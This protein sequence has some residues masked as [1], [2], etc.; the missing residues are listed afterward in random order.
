MKKA[1]IIALGAC[2]ALTACGKK[3]AVAIPSGYRIKKTYYY[4]SME[5]CIREARKESH[6][7]DARDTREINRGAGFMITGSLDNDRSVVFVCNPGINTN[8]VFS[9]AVKQDPPEKRQA[10]VLPGD[11]RHKIQG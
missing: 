9:I 6:H 5:S 10:G 3:S 4:Y 8:A 7:E 11:A 2:L 1:L